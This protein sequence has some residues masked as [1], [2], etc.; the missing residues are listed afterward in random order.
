MA[1]KEKKMHEEMDKKMKEEQQEE[2]PE[3]KQE[4]KKKEKKRAKKDEEIAS[5]Q[6]EVQNLKDRLLR[7]QAELANF[8]RRMNEERL[9]DLKYANA[10]LAKSLLPVIDSFRIALDKESGGE[11]KPYL[12]GFEMILRDLVKALKEAGLEEI[13][14]EGEPFDPSLHQAVAKEERDDVEAGI[15]VEE[16]QKGY[17]FKDRLL[18]AAMVKV[19]ERPEKSAEEKDPTHEGEC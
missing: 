7:N 2:K 1:E 10:E 3:E 8:K 16:F 4:T 15:V 13:E 14:A 5:L 17:K 19:S 18:R 9:K 12:K 6:E 11:K